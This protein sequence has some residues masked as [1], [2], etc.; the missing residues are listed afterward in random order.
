MRQG[1]RY[2]RS[3]LAAG[4]TS[5]FLA[6]LTPLPVSMATDM[7][8]LGVARFT[9]RAGVSHAPPALPLHCTCSI[10]SGGSAGASAAYYALDTVASWVGPET[11]LVGAPDAGFFLDAFN[12]GRCV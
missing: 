3:R 1:G 8:V 7:S 11:R 12:V 5:V 10:L 9:C 6:P 4:T 2:G